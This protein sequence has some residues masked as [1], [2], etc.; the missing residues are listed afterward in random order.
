MGMYVLVVWYTTFYSD[1]GVSMQD[2]NT[3]QSCE[4]A[5]VIVLSHLPYGKAECVE[6]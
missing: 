5:K 4:A 6:K 3:K 1:K 2:F